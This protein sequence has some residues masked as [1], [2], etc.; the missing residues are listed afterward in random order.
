MSNGLK[1]IFSMIMFLLLMFF[2]HMIH[3]EELESIETEQL[4]K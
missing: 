2:V 1:Y 4:T 3:N